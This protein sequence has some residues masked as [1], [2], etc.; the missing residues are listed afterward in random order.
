MRQILNTSQAL[1]QFVG[2]LSSRADLFNV[3]ESGRLPKLMELCVLFT[4]QVGLE[5]PWRDHPTLLETRKARHLVSM[6]RRDI[7]NWC[8]ARTASILNNGCNV[9]LDRF[10]SGADVTVLCD[11]AEDLAGEIDRLW[12]AIAKE[13]SEIEETLGRALGYACDMRDVGGSEDDVCVGEH[14]PVTLCREA[15]HRIEDLEEALAMAGTA[16][17]Q[18][19][20][21]VAKDNPQLAFVAEIEQRLAK[22]ILDRSRN[23]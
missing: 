4:S 2:F 20:D 12:R 16:L 1:A 6:I 17:A 13:G 3:D 11:L 10:V 15:A 22:L 14:T 5:D 8:R 21:T 23:R 7:A 19:R 9:A 18:V